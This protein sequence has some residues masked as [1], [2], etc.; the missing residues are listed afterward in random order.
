MMPVRADRK[1][2][3]STQLR[4]R[5]HPLSGPV[6]KPVYAS[7]PLSSSYCHIDEDDF[8]SSMSIDCEFEL[9]DATWSCRLKT[10]EMG[11]LIDREDPNLSVSHLDFVDAAWRL[12]KSPIGTEGEIGELKQERAID[13][14]V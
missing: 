6:L 2:V 9:I 3:R 13:A 5:L 10:V 14:V 12:C 1:I 7:S 8:S 11:G 4:I